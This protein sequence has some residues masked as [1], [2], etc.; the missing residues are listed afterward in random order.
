MMKIE[1]VKCDSCGKVIENNHGFTLTITP[2]KTNELQLCPTY[3]LEETKDLCASC[4]NLTFPN[5][6]PCITKLEN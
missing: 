4:Y 1:L 6:E 5:L 2:M 3:M